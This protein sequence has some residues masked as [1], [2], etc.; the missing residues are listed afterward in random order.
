MVCG[1]TVSRIRAAAKAAESS[2][3]Q[4]RSAA[5]APQRKGVQVLR[6]HWPLPHLTPTHTP[7]PTHAPRTPPSSPGCKLCPRVFPHTLYLRVVPP[8][9]SA[10][11]CQVRACLFGGTPVSTPCTHTHTHTHTHHITSHHITSHTRARVH[12]HIHTHHITSH[13]YMDMRTH[14]CTYLHIPLAHTHA[15]THH[16]HICT[17]ICTYTHPLHTHHIYAQTHT[18]SH[19]LSGWY[20]WL[21]VV[22]HWPP[23]CT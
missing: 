17:H 4:Q 8:V 13:T 23:V 6:L 7:H 3:W 5:P 20:L 16:I 14:M 1:P 12:T 2:G 10:G 9:A 21:E 18:L 11:P 19:S 15:H 22:Q